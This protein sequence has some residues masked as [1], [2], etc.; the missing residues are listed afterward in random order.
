MKKL[1]KILALALV[2]VFALTAFAGCGNGSATLPDPTPDADGNITLLIGGVGPLT[3][4]YANY[5]LSVKYGCEIAVEEINAAGGVNGMKLALDYQDSQ[6]DP[7]AA[8][9]AYGNLIDKGMDVSL[10][11]VLSG[12]T[13][14][15]V[16]AAK[17]DG[18]LVLTPSG[19]AK[20]AI[21]GNDNAFRVCFNDPQQGTVSADFIADNT[22]AT[23]VAVFYQSDIDYS[24]GLYETFK[25]QAA[26]RGIEIVT[27]QTFTA[28]TSTD[29]KTQINAIKTS[30]AELVFIPIYAAEAANFLTQAKTEGLTNVTFFG[31][32]GIDG[33]LTKGVAK[34]DV[35][36]LM[37]LTPFA[38]DSTDENVKS[39]VTK[40]QEKH[41][42]TPDQFAADG[43]DAIY[44]IKAAIEKAGLK[45]EDVTNFHS[46]LVAAMTQI[47]VNGVT[48]TMTW[49][50]DGETQKEAN[51]LVYRDGVA[52]AFSK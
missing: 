9:S 41:N 7:D 34:E 16:A 23:K 5:G 48:G 51:A 35:E 45:K 8:Q 24:N 28:S 10:G 26:A 29:F 2:A 18:I 19:S 42:T 36:G 52:V 3:G 17:N 21:A 27:T 25:T 15:I 22:L 31:C 47:T 14:S 11:A 30:G 37:M 6:G 12:E 20:D 33:I 4:D 46:R 50:A 38:A 1:T 43:Y 40:Y 39:F 32:D 44:A 49:T 13:A